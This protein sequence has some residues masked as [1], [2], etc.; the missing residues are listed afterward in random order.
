MMRVELRLER[1][2]NAAE[3]LGT[4]P[5]DGGGDVADEVSVGD[6]RL[7]RGV[8]REWSGNC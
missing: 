8:I 3:R 7:S 4:A 2:E 5:F 1:L 6:G